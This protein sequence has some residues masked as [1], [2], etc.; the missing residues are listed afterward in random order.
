M[1][2]FACC[3]SNC[4]LASDVSIALMRTRSPILSKFC[5]PFLRHSSGILRYSPECVELEF[6]ELRLLGILRSSRPIISNLAY[7]LACRGVEKNG[8]LTD[9]LEDS[10]LVRWFTSA[11]AP[12]SVYRQTRCEAGRKA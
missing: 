9:R 11:G 4:L 12:A 10:K 7:N 6:C 3:P 8:H 5:S 1:I 2:T